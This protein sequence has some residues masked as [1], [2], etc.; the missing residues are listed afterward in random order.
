MR[1][2]LGDAPSTL[3][4]PTYTGSLMRFASRSM[5]EMLYVSIVPVSFTYVHA[6]VGR[7]HSSQN[8]RGGKRTRSHFLHVRAIRRPFFSSARNRDIASPA[9]QENFASGRNLTDVTF[10]SNSFALN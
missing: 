5:Y 1:P 2:I 4:T 6:S 8:I 10:P 9:D 3:T 7:K